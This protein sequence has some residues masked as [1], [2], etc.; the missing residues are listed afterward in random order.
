MVKR[1]F[2]PKPQ[3][4]SVLKLSTAQEKFASSSEVH[5]NSH[6]GWSVFT[7]SGFK[8]SIFGAVMSE[9]KKRTDVKIMA[10]SNTISCNSLCQKT[11]LKHG[12]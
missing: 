1:P 2:R 9:K 12:D 5:V 10:V 7:G 11:N 8:S 4:A 6:V 3:S